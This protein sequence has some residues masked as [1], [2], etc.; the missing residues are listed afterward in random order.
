[1][2]IQQQ[3]SFFRGSVST[4]FSAIEK[5]SGIGPQQETTFLT[6]LPCTVALTIILSCVGCGSA[7]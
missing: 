5:K 4:G 1:M 7:Y 2:A 6:S 3:A